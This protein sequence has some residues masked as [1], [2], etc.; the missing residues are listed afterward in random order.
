[1]S[2]N[3]PQFNP[4]PF[5]WKHGKGWFDAG[6]QIFL[7]VKKQWFVACIL[8]GLLMVLVGGINPQLMSVAMVFVAPV[9]TAYMM[10][11]CRL[12]GQTANPTS[13]GWQAV[14]AQ[15]APLLVLGVL[16]GLL[17]VLFSYVHDQILLAY[18]LPVVLTE[19]L[20]K[21]MS[22]RESLFRALLSLLTQLPV[23]VALAFAPALI[24]FHQTLPFKAMQYSA[25]AVL[26]TWKAFM[27]L[28]L[29]FMLLFFAIL[30][31]ASLLFSLMMTLAGG[32]HAMMINVVVLFLLVTAGGMG[33]G[34]QY[35]AYTEVFVTEDEPD[36][37]NGNDDG[38]E[39]Y[40]EI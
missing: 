26:R 19:E 40:A 10:N 37:P 21:N 36:K 2:D 29:L 16:S 23:V 3:I 14:G 15:L 9:L 25:V 4:Q 8:V 24:L 11:C 18:G 5:T 12:A 13:T 6:I 30:M 33:L 32:I 1:M 22:G 20:V 7:R 34:A 35:Q 31:V 28:T 27:A 17:S 38:T 39:V